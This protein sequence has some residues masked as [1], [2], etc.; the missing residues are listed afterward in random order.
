MNFDIRL[1]F[2][3]YA[4]DLTPQILSNGWRKWP[5]F[6]Q[7]IRFLYTFED[8]NWSVRE[9]VRDFENS[10]VQSRFGPYPRKLII[11]PRNEALNLP[12]KALM[13]MEHSA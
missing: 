11:S 5:K 6:L 10:L 8:Y 13:A 9:L 7:K 2:E 4:A 1:F 12:S 3:N